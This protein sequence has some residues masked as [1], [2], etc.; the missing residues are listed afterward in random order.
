M[1]QDHHRFYLIGGTCA[2][3]DIRLCKNR[4]AAD[5]VEKCAGCFDRRNVMLARGWDPCS[6]IYRLHGSLAFPKS[7]L[8]RDD[9]CG[10]VEILTE[11]CV[12]LEPVLIVGFDPV[13]AAIPES[14]ESNSPVDLA[15][16][17]ER[18]DFVILS[19]RIF[20]SFAQRI[21]RSIANAKNGHTIVVQPVAEMPVILGEIRRNKY[22]VHK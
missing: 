7:K 10:D 16:V 20:N 11:L 14:Q 17:F 5:I 21:I 8:M 6:L 4:I 22:E 13:N 12:K 15:I 1:P 9:S 2:D 19:Q 18:I 3:P